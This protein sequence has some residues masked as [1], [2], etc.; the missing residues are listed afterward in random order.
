MNQDYT[1]VNMWASYKREYLDV[2]NGLN[3]FFIIFD[4]LLM[5]LVYEV[6]YY[7]RNIQSN[8]NGQPQVNTISIS[9][10]GVVVNENFQNA[11]I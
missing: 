1:K 11:H 2:L 8:K 4:I 5:F 9:E 6:Y 7:F 10:N 3:I